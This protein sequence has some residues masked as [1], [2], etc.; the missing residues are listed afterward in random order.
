M[1]K[2]VWFKRATNSFRKT[3]NYIESDYLQ[4]VGNVTKVLL[5][6]LKKSHGKNIYR[7]Y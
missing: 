3:L 1:R 4:N 7:T 5:Q 2:L 6:Q